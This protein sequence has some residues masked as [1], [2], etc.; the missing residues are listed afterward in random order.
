MLVEFW[1]EIVVKNFAL[2]LLVIYLLTILSTAIMV[3]HEKRDPAKTS[4]WVLILILMP[5]IG[6][7]FYI[8]F[9][10][11]HRKEKIFSRKG[12]RDLQQIELISQN[13][14]KAIK[15]KK[16]IDIPC[17]AEN[18]KIITLLL[19]NSK[20][21]LTLY[22]SVNIL[23]TGPKTFKS[24]IEA[25]DGAESS[26][27]LEFYIIDNDGIGN[28]IKEKLIAKAN[29]GIEVRLIFDD[30]GSWHLPKRYINELKDAGVEVHPFMKVNFPWLTSK[31][32]YRNHRKIIVIDG[33]IAFMG[34]INIADRYLKGDSTLGTWF[35]TVLRIE[36]EAVRTLQVIFLTDW[37][38]VSNIIISNRD[39]YFPE[40]TPARQQ[41]LQVT[42]SGPDSDW[43]SIMQ[44]F[45]AA[46]TKA[47]KNI[48]IATP[49]FIPNESILTALKTASLS[50]VDV[51]IMLPGK[52]DSTVVYWSSMSY[53]SELLDAGINVHLFQGGFNHS[54]ILMI[55][56]N[57]ASV[58][59]ANMDIRSF[60]D[61]FELLTMI[62]DKELT[63]QLEEQYIKD[64]RRC[65]EL[66][67][68]Q[69]NNRLVKQTFKESVARLFSPLF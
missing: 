26:I 14:L 31:A 60:E 39:K 16:Y 27:H 9:G 55:D 5:I 40:Y 25:I 19:N 54:K 64:L 38:F 57:F 21:L 4:I 62:Y 56:G 2:I 59:S 11:N 13:Q 37:F 3:I 20:A 49:Y 67:L 68:K 47:R 65:K 32:N 58:G 36:G 52:S 51:R 66:N 18:I 41:A 17:I 45:F 10:Q 46:I 61:N 44:A 34:G 33:K 29:S 8:F 53:V 24:I 15:E 48:Y 7:I 50:G 43:S 12:L 28:L 69:W 30:V 63:L 23:Q 22:N 42:S 1:R 35:D 6:L